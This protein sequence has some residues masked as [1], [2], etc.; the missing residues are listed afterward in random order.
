MA[1]VG[2]GVAVFVLLT[3]VC[4][5]IY[6]STLNVQLSERMKH[7]ERE[8][9]ALKAENEAMHG[10]LNGLIQNYL[11]L[12]ESYAWL[13]ATYAGLLQEHL[14]LEAKYDALEDAYR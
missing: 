4:S 9:D 3:L 5:T 11:T 1:A 8:K 12:E 6:F 14:A 2:K 10:E 7:A 13:N